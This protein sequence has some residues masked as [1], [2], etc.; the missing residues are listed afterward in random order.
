MLQRPAVSSIGRFLS[1]RDNFTTDLALLEQVVL[2][3]AALEA[4]GGGPDAADL[5]QDALA[6]ACRFL[7]IGIASP[8]PA[9]LYRR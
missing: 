3:T 6:M 4:D 2:E 5:F 8:G 1:E 7:P 9:S